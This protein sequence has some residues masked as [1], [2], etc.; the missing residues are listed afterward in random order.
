MDFWQGKRVLVTGATGFLGGWICRQ[1]LAQGALLTTVQR[2]PRPQSQFTLAG[3]AGHSHIIQGSLDDT[4]LMDALF[5]TQSFD[6]VFH[7][8]SMV[9]VNAALA[10]PL[11]ALQASI[12]TTAALLE[13]VRHKQPGAIVIIASSDKAYGHQSVPFRED[14]PLEPL[15]PYEIAKAT[16]DLLA[17]SYGRLYGLNTAITRCGNF[18]GGY[19]FAFARIIPYCIA[20]ALRGQAPVLRSDGQFTRDFLYVEEAAKAHLMLAEHLAG[21]ASLRGEAFN[22]SYEVDITIVDLVTRILAL[23]GSSLT[24]IIAS[25]AKAEIAHL[26]L[27]TRKARTRLN[28]QP[29]TDFNAG[30]ARTIAWYREH[31]DLF[32]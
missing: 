3:F 31:Q 13:Q 17:Q 20:Q 1:L 32:I 7:L 10:D 21:D 27:D 4:S 12:G 29:E 18:F 22:F 24:P 8:A 30:L 2:G 19:D 28:W 25:T 5:T 16:Q 15:H 23:M 26:R 14:R 6:A 9:D 11:A